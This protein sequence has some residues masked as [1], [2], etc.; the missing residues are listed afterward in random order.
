MNA[1]FFPLPNQ[2]V[3]QDRFK[4]PSVAAEKAKSRWDDLPAYEVEHMDYDYIGK[5]EDLAE[6]R[7]LYTVLTSG[8]EGRYCELEK[9]CEE[10]MLK[11]MSPIQ[12]VMA[13]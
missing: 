8:K 4:G 10:K 5:C 13:V 3:F 9:F 1:I 11:L 2:R 7:D 6:L 12:A